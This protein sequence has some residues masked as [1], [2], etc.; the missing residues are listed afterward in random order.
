MTLCWDQIYLQNFNII[1]YWIRLH[2]KIIVPSL[3]GGYF[4]TTKYNQN[5]HPLFEKL[6][7][8]EGIFDYVGPILKPRTWVPIICK[9]VSI[10][11]SGGSEGS[12][13]SVGNVNIYYNS[14]YSGGP[15]GAVKSVGGLK[16]YYNSAY[17]GGPAG[18]IKSTSGSVN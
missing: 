3:G 17:S 5:L 10:K 7:I 6:G 16:V 11:W 9:Y 8:N 12:V 14:A 15:E 2:F 1:V 13:K 18:S 4:Y